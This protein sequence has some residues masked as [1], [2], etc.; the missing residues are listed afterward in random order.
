MKVLWRR[1]K[2]YCCSCGRLGYT[3]TVPEG[4][5]AAKYQPVECGKCSGRQ[6]RE[7]TA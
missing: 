5:D 7:E 1:V 4:Q 6:W 3:A 2:F